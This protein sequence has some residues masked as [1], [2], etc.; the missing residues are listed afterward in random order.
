MLE[1]VSRTGPRLASQ[2]RSVYD[3]R[4]LAKAT[5]SFLRQPA[6]STLSEFS[7]RAP[8]AFFAA[9]EAITEHSRHSFLATK[10]MDLK[11]VRLLF[12][13]RLGIDPPDVFL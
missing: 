10:K 4:R 13:A 7:G 8:R 3:A 1:N 5:G 2:L 12:S 9:I 11:T 6:Q